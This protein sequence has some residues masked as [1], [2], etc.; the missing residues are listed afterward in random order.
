[1]FN[2][3]FK[4]FLNLCMFIRF[5]TCSFLRKLPMRVMS[6]KIITL[7][8]LLFGY[9]ECKKEAIIDDFADFEDFDDGEAVVSI[10][11]EQ[12]DATQIKNSEDVLVRAADHQYRNDDDDSIDADSEFDH[13][14]DEEEFE[15]FDK[16]TPSIPIL[17]QKTGEPKLTVAKVPLH[18]G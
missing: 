17:D 7:L 10:L 16:D 1:M 6:L 15:G 2:N 4:P 18:F 5:E 11:D 13:F 12:S 8:F 14:T 3:R 9:I